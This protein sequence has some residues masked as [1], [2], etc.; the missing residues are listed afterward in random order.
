[1]KIA[2]I[3]GNICTSIIH[4]T[5]ENAE[6]LLRYRAL[7]GADTVAELPEGYEIGDRYDGEKWTKA[8]KK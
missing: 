2:A 6:F 3:R 7:N 1:M 8:V 4:G 5:M